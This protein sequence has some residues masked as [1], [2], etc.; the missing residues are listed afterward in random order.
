MGPPHPLSDLSGSGE[1]P[2]QAGHL[3]QR[4]MF[5]RAW[6]LSRVTPQLPHPGNTA[7]SSLP[8]LEAGRVQD[9]GGSIKSEVNCP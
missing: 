1:A 5:R 6:D 2:S 7:P 3:S 9:N 4:Q 8:K